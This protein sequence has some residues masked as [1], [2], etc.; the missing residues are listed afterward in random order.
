MVDTFTLLNSRIKQY[1]YTCKKVV[2]CDDIVI[3]AGSLYEDSMHI[4]CHTI[5]GNVVQNIT[6]QLI[7][8]SLYLYIHTHTY[9][10]IYIQ[11]TIYYDASDNSRHTGPGKGT[12]PFEFVRLKTVDLTIRSQIKLH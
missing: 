8:V 3:V 9:I 7:H 4:R 2:L 10:Y 12:Q 11:C 1:M 5:F 6:Y